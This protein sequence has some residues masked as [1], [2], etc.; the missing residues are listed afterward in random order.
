MTRLAFIAGLVSI[1]WPHRAEALDHLG[2]DWVT[3]GPFYVTAA[4]T[5]EEPQYYSPGG[6]VK[7]EHCRHCGMLRL[8]R[9][10]WGESGSYLP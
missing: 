5:Y 10:L 7:V 4:M 8:P 9:K 6:L 1:F 3:G 2:A